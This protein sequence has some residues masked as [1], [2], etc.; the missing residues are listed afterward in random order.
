MLSAWI[1]CRDLTKWECEWFS[2]V[3]ETQNIS[4]F[5]P[6]LINCPQK[7]ATFPTRNMGGG[8]RLF[9]TFPNNHKFWEPSLSLEVNCTSSSYG[10]CNALFRPKVTFEVNPDISLEKP[11]QFPN[12]I[13][14]KS[15]LTQTFKFLLPPVSHCCIKT[16]FAYI[17][18]HIFWG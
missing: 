17:W 7:S 1:F 14:S 2:T 5:I 4:K 8:Q 11:I 16:N 10:I 18:T 3:K 9:E 12:T 15:H 6:T 13:G